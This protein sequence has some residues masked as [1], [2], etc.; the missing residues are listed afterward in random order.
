[1][2]YTDR[3][4]IFFVPV[5]I[6]IAPCGWG[7]TALN[8]TSLLIMRPQGVAEKLQAPCWHWQKFQAIPQI[9]GGN[10]HK[11]TGPL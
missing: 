7:V 10:G 6:R 8:V 3:R 4:I 1:M 9:L 5:T 11:N 2:T